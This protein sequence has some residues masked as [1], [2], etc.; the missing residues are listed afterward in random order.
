MGS[1]LARCSSSWQRSWLFALLAACSLG[2]CQSDVAEKEDEDDATFFERLAGAQRERDDAAR[3]PREEVEEADRERRALAQ[4]EGSRVPPA[5][6]PRRRAALRVEWEALSR[7]RELLESSRHRQPQAA[8]APEMRIVLLSE[9]HPEAI[10][11][12]QPSSGA[13]RERYAHTAVVGDDE[14]LALVEGLEKRGLL[15]Y[16]RPTDASELQWTNAAARGR[17]T[18]EQPGGSVTLLSM[19]GQGTNPATKEIPALYS[20][21]KRAIAVLRNRAA[22]IQVTTSV[23]GTGAL[24]GAR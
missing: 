13:D 23:R 8:A 22:S 24:P 20:E 15:K 17:V 11:A 4:A 14:L 18:I 2:G 19:R 7:E 21:A 5:A 1:L 9:S 6:A 3:R 10:A 16:A 12:R